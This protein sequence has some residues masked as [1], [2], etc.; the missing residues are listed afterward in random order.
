M[1]EVDI[2]QRFVE[3]RERL[4]FSQSAFARMMDVARETLRKA[5]AGLSEFRSDLLSAA[6]K[7]GVD[8]QYVMTG[9]RSKNLDAVAREVGYEHQTIHGDVSG[10]GFAGPGANVQIIHTQNHVTRTKAETKPG[11]EHI[12][13]GQ[14]AEL[15]QLVD[16]IVETEAKLRKDPK[17]HRAVWAALNAHCGVP[18]YSLIA[19]GDFEK[20]R[21]YLHQWQGRLGSLATAPVKDGDNWRK[22]HYAYIKINTREPEDAAALDAYMARTFKAASLTDL[23]NEQLERVYRYVAGRRNRRK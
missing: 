7:L 13:V 18:T 11:V 16:G 20:A 6:A 23:S 4:G 10:V 19:A 5:E 15:K 21:K 14:R 12:T 8:I 1:K 3:E 17:S 9:I 22:R 2:A